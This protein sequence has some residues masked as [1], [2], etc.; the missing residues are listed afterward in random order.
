MEVLE[1]EIRNTLLGSEG[2]LQARVLAVKVLRNVPEKA[3]AR[4]RSKNIGNTVG[5]EVDGV[6]DE[7]QGTPHEGHGVVQ[8]STLVP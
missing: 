2:S 7:V 6:Q 5:V 4:N 8:G 3:G 1:G